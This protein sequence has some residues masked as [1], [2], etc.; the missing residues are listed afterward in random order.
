[1]LND[2]LNIA[3]PEQIQNETQL[4]GRAFE[5]KIMDVFN[6]NGLVPLVIEKKYIKRSNY[7]HLPDGKYYIHQPY[8]SQMSPDF[9]LV[10]TNNGF[11]KVLKLECKIGN[12]VIMWNDGF[13]EEGVIYVFC[14]RKHGTKIFTASDLLTE[15][16]RS[17]RELYEK[18]KNKLN[19]KLRHELKD[20]KFHPTVRGA[21]SLS[22]VCSHNSSDIECLFSSFLDMEF[23]TYKRGISLFS[24]AGGDT[25]GMEN[26][27]IRVIG[28]VE[29]DANAIKTHETNFPDS[30]LIG[31]DITDISP[32]EFKK[33]KGRIDY[34][35]GG[36]PCQSFSHGGKKDE[37]DPRGQ[38]Y[39]Y[40][41]RAVSCIKPKW[42]IG[43]NVKGIIA[44]QREGTSM[45]DV[46]VNGFSRINYNMNYTLVNSKN[47][48]IPQDR[49]RV[50]FV[51]TRG[52]LKTIPI[53]NDRKTVLRDILEP[54]LHNALPITA[55]NQ[56]LT[57][58]PESKF[59][60]GY[61]EITGKPPTNLVKCSRRREEKDDITFGK[62]GKSTFSCL[63]DIDEVSRTLISTYGT[64]PRLFVPVIADNNRYMRPYTILECQR[65]Q[66][67]PDTMRFI[68]NET[69]IIK[70][71]GNAVP[72]AIITAVVDY[73]EQ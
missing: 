49:Q 12:D 72:P 55:H 18:E 56:Y 60:V 66:G 14:C 54:S 4:N 58:I 21:W 73:L 20:E 33:Y 46:V 8:G 23:T 68:G 67:F 45:A 48:G 50:I 19:L 28:Y 51:G 57:D 6:N 43:E 17:T 70:Q 71:I 52:E 42:V 32:L 41:I 9:I 36:F 11:S 3:S 1:M 35:F 7:H 13:P 15:K 5:N 63:V 59:I 26:A 27:G 69:S 2:I 44:R 38:L 22:D 62:R 29:K 24:G 65:I 30:V 25:I 64:F 39:I 47:F 34:V 31:T 61:G 10:H 40:F 37:K 53:T 16:A